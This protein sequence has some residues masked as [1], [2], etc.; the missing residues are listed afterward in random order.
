MFWRKKKRMAALTAG[1]TAPAISLPLTGGGQFKLNESLRR[2]PVLLAFFKVSCPVCQFT[3]PYLE[4]IYK[5]Y[6]DSKVSIVAVS[7]NSERDTLAFMKQYGITFPV[8]LDDTERYPV[9]NAYGLTNVPTL[10]LV[11][12]DGEIELSSVGW[13]RADIAAVGAQMARVDAVPNFAVFRPGE[14][15]PEFTAG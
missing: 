9:S 5:A 2:G 8:A 6:P 11:M 3:F 15:V 13:S 7:Q 12:P 1:T 4:R 10:F 14:N